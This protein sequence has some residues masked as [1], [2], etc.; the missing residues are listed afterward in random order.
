ME[1]RDQLESSLQSAIKARDRVTITALRSAL[2]AIDNASAVE[3]ARAWPPRLGVG[4]GEAVRRVLSM[5]EVVAIL[6]AEIAERTTAADEF[7]R[8]R[9]PAESAR[10]RAEARVLR[11]H[12]PEA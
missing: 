3:P 2:G 12:L 10:L 11:A 8:L 6:H 4:A 9:R 7:E 1:L 5:E